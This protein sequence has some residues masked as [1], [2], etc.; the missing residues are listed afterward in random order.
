MKERPLKFWYLSY[1]GKHYILHPWKFIKDVIYSFK[2]AYHRMR[3]GYNHTELFNTDWYLLNIAANMIDTL[4]ATSLGWLEETPEWSTKEDWCAEL[5][6][7]AGLLRLCDGEVED[8]NEYLNGT[9]LEPVQHLP[10]INK[11]VLTETE[12]AELEETT[13]KYMRNALLTRFVRTKAFA[14]LNEVFDTLWD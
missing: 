2:S 1:S 13:G 8:F 9:M 12:E 11:Y 6:V 7:L 4:A 3:Y 5:H 14:R 10:C